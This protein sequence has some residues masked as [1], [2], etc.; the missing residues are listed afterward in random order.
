MKTIASVPVFEIE[1]D[2]NAKLF[3]PAQ[4]AQLQ[5]HIG[6][7][8]VTDLILFAH[9]W[10]NDIA[11]A[12]DLYTRFFSEVGGALSN[13]SVPALSGR[14]F[15]GAVTLW[16]SKKFTDK[17]L[18]P[19]G[20]A[21]S[22][23]KDEAKIVKARLKDFAKDTVRLGKTVPASAATRKKV[24]RATALLPKLETDV[25]AQAQFVK[26]IRS[27]LNDKAAEKDD[28]TK[29]FFRTKDAELLQNL[30]KEAVVVPPARG[31]GAADLGSLDSAVAGGAA[32]FFSDLGD[33]V[34]AGA[35]RLLNF[36]TYYRMKERAGRVGENGLAPL[37]EKL[38]KAA[39]QL[40]IHL[41]GHSFGGR[42]VTAA[43]NAAPSAARPNSMTLL[44][45]AF[46]HNG[47]ASKF[48][49]KTDGFFRKVI[50]GAKVRGPI[51]ITHT[52]ND[53]AVGI[54]YPL[55]SR[56][57]GVKTAALGDEND[58]YGGIGRNGAQKTPEAVAGDL[59]VVGR[60]YAFAAGK[61]F[62][63]KSDA[64]ISDHSDIC[65]PQVAWALLSSIA[66]T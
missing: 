33:S 63:L 3:S 60:P 42:L 16:P 65:K 13:G 40:R 48:D 18:I 59:L 4:L 5:S 26:I 39:P 51:L 22:L 21:A 62:N 28:G 64:F 11:D 43:A 55:A 47:L 54:A 2:K 36:T 9:G 20:G 7:A 12:R 58:P 49:G 61:A 29:E 52:K 25:K 32:G 46:S 37:L 8:G 15:A 23:A 27:L 41:V 56:I 30:R 19:G 6:S 24:E 1:F 35:R 44:Q 57:N 66:T 17:D 14:R 38:R 34:T 10:N 45:A 50:T 53:Q 31:G